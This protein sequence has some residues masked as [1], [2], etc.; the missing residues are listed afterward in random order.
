MQILASCFYDV[1]KLKDVSNG[2]LFVGIA[3]KL[4]ARGST[5]SRSKLPE[6][7]ADSVA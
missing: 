3:A 6:L 5:V 2:V 1:E 7:S 4:L